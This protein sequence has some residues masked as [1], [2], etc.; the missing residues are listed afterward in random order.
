MSIESVMPSNHLLL[1]RPLLLLPPIPPSIRIF[2]NESTL[3]MRW[4]K[5]WSFSFNISPSKEHPELISFKMDW[6]DL[7]AVQGTLKSPEPPLNQYLI[8]RQLAV[9]FC[10][11][12]PRKPPE[13]AIISFKNYETMIPHSSYLVIVEKFEAILIL[14]N[15]STECVPFSC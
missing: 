15:S 8:S 14:F 7:L 13:P 10:D 1:C 3:H 12:D 4:P 9:L 6:F 11:G 2:S 5:S